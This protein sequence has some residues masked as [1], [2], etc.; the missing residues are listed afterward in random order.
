MPLSE[1]SRRAGLP[2]THYFLSISRGDAIRT[3]RVGPRSFWS[4]VALL[5]L[6]L[7][8]G[9]FGAADLAFRAPLAVVEAAGPPVI[10]TSD[11]DE[12]NSSLLRQF[13]AAIGPKTLA[14]RIS[15]LVARQE[16]LEKRD[17][18]VAALAAEAAALS[19]Q[20]SLDAVGAIESLGPKPRRQEGAGLI[21]GGTARAY[22]PAGSDPPP[23]AAAPRGLEESAADPR[24]APSY[25]TIA[26]NPELEA[27][28]RLDLLGRSLERLEGDAM[29][30]LAAIDRKAS[31]ASGRN[32][33]I[34]A[35][36]G[37]D[38]E[39]IAAPKPPS[40]GGP[41]IPVDADPKAPAFERAA[42][43]AARDVSFAENLSALMPSVPLMKPLAGE[44]SV[45]SPFGYRIDPFLGRPALHPGV[46]LLQP[47]GADIFATAAGRV[48]HAGPMGGYG[49]AVEIDHG[50]GLST[51]YGHLS[52]ILVAE[53]Q[54]VALGDPIGRLGS[55]GRSTGPHLHYE[56]RVDGEPVDPERFIRA[57]AEMGA[58]E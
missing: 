4:I 41:F 21:D 53:G 33:E 30:A 5:P 31:R 45:S 14:D 23:N 52:E 15:A 12:Q 22:A 1:R 54:R 40:M 25:A 51:R 17:A 49:D 32:A 35:K 3:A 46:D 42:A 16:R 27:S 36:V 48:T 13:G 58:G 56:V 18:I 6:S 57:G 34:L 29:T 24:Q 38:P 39:K 44:A 19:P 7:G 20:P 2:S 9:L 26:A 55:T 43:R 37:L 50:H 10:E 8:F 28:A 11:P 47:Y